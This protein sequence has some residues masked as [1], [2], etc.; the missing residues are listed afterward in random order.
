ML[1]ILTD[2]PANTI[3]NDTP[4]GVNMRDLGA[5]SADKMYQDNNAN[6]LS[7][8]SN[9]MV[10]RKEAAM[11]VIQQK[12]SSNYNGH[13]FS[14]LDAFVRNT[15]RSNNNVNNTTM[16]DKYMQRTSF[17]KGPLQVLRGV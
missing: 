15:E 5:F 11:S 2:N 8:R 3:E 14:A 17:N 16:K 9:T 1:D 4:K 10:E 13:T 6:D 12:G 7:P